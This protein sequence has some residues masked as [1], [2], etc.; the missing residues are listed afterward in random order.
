LT[1][2][3]PLPFL[4]SVVIVNWNSRDDLKDCLCAL[5]AQADQMF[6]TIVVDNGS[7]DDSVHMVE[8]EFPTVRL[9]ATGENLGFAEGCNRGIEVAEGEWIAL[10]NND[11]VADPQWIAELRKQAVALPQDVGMLQSKLLFKS[12]PARIN[13]AGLLLFQN[14]TARDW[15][16][17]NVDL[18]R[19]AV[20]E[21]FAPTAGA[22]L[23][24]RTMLEAVRQSTGYLDRG[25]FM[26]F[27]DVDL[28]WRCRLA[29]WRSF[30]VPTS[31]VLH[32]F[33]KSTMRKPGDFVG[34]HSRK[35]RLRSLAK[36]ASLDFFVAALPKTISDV[37][38]I[39][40][41]RGMRDLHA[42]F[43]LFLEGLA[44]RAESE[45][46]VRVPRWSVERAWVTRR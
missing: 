46:A 11:T 10:L 43:K 20:E 12:N 38:W 2:V 13:S 8:V 4:I 41:W 3:E 15:Q 7:E 6:E 24:R 16:F 19:T 17:D 37:F 23:Y 9:L 21:I 42:A 28:G 25:F 36:N 1:T 27:E 22:A 39:L 32:A 34:W 33:Q 44:L 29:G 14:A 18:G 26:Y 45:G 40:R 5:A 31:F 35:N 30:Y